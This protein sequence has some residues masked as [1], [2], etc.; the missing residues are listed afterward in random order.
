MVNSGLTRK[1]II[2]GLRASSIPVELQSDIRDLLDEIE[3]QLYSPM[4]GDLQKENLFNRAEELNVK[5]Q[6][7]FS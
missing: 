3:Q 7:H 5:I 1:D 2:L 4:G 6:D